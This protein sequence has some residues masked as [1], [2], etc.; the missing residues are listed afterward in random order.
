MLYR[1]R[2]GATGLDSGSCHIALQFCRLSGGFGRTE[3][4]HM[5]VADLH[6]LFILMFTI[7]Y[8]CAIILGEKNSNERKNFA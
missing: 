4:K 1:G 3:R 7:T 8:S 6:N 5:N 2:S